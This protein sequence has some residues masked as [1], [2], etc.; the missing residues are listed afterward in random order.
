[1]NDRSFRT[2]DGAFLGRLRAIVGDAAVV[3]ERDALDDYSH[4]EF[5][6]EDIRRLPDAAVKPRSAGEVAQVLQLCNGQRIPVTARGG[7]TGLCGGCV[8]VFGGIVLSLEN[9]KRIVDV[10]DRNLTATVEAGLMLMDFYPAVEKKGLFFPPHPGDES[11]TIGG[12]IATNAGGA[13]AVKYGVIRNFVKGIEVALPDGSVLVF[14]GPCIKDSSGYS[15]MHLMIGSE[16]TL[17]IVT[18]ATIALMAPPQVVI[19]LVAPYRSLHDAIATV[20]T[21]LQRKIL[22]MAIEFVDRESVRITGDFINKAWPCADGEAHLMIILDG[23][24]DGEVMAAAETLGGICMEHGALDMFVADTKAKQRDILDIRSN[25]Y[26]AMRNHMLEIL[27]ITV[28]RARIAEYVDAVQSLAKELNTW[29]PTYGHAAD[30]NVHTHIMRERWADG[31]WTEIPGWEATYRKVRDRLHQIGKSLR[32]IPSGEHGIGLVKKDYLK[33]FLD[34]RAI[35][36][37]RN[38]KGVFDPNGILNPGK[39]FD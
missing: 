11:A 34:P 3:T 27:D 17:G 31:Q 19:T 20:P 26:E 37:M 32:G 24:S 15:L 25:I 18:Q 28:P 7:G 30:G 10:D 6:V 35:D 38:I 4:D 29:L 23:P 9:M 12:V 36:L 33:A 16:G 1:M 13:R 14:G 39:I 22:P 8:P 5:S 2:V 21:I